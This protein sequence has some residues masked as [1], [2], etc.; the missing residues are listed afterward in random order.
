[1]S[2]EKQVS[3][4]LMFVCLHM[5]VSSSQHKC[6]KNKIMIYVGGTEGSSVE[7]KWIETKLFNWRF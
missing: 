3:G 1:M 2:A 5:H 6:M 7:I 4:A